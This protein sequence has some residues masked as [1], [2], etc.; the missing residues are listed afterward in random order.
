MTE[1]AQQEMDST[2]ETGPGAPVAE[3]R[4]RRVIALWPLWIASVVLLLLAIAGVGAY[5]LSREPNV[6]ERI[7]PPSPPEQPSAETVRRAEALRGLNDALE[8]Q[9]SD[10]HKQIET[11]QCPPGTEL[12]PAAAGKTTLDTTPDPVLDSGSG[13]IVR[14]ALLTGA[15]A[16]QAPPP[17]SP[18]P[19]LS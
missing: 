12:D 1:T 19:R 16:D 8:G 4:S 11:P 17:P 9:I 14:S 18:I 15:A 10:L 13:P 5:L 3:P 2:G 6:A 7:L